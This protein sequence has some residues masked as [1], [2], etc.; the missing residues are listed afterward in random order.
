MWFKSAPPPSPAYRSSSLC[1]T[2]PP[3]SE[4]GKSSAASGKLV[5]WSHFSPQ[6]LHNSAVLITAMSLKTV[7]TLLLIG[8]LHHFLN[9]PYSGFA[10]TTLSKLYLTLPRLTAQSSGQFQSSLTC[11][12]VSIGLFYLPNICFTCLLKTTPPSSLTHPSQPLLQVPP[13][14]FLITFLMLGSQGA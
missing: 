12:L 14:F 8:L 11:P 6:R 3:T 4:A 9:P 2:I 13:Y 5:S 10:L 1:W 7:Y